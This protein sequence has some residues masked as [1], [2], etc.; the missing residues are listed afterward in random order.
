MQPET[1]K[2]IPASSEPAYGSL[3]PRPVLRSRHRI[4]VIVAAV[5]GVVLVAVGSFSIGFSA[6]LHKARFSYR[7]GE[8]YERNFMKSERQGM[9]DRIMKKMDG[10]LFRSG[11]GV[12][13]EILSIR[14]GLI[15]VSGPEGQENSIVISD[16][17]VIMKGGEKVAFSD[18]GSGDRIVVLGKPGDDG[19]IQADLIRVFDTDRNSQDGPIQKLLR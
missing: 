11:H 10:K 7:F 8:N 2:G 15:I 13:G 19:V 3:S 1:S 17:A 18:L 12:A 9:K 4:L 16:D 14:E 5:T 6:G